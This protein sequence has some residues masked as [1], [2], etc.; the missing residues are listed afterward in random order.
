MQYCILARVPILTNTVK[1]GY[2]KIN[3]LENLRKQWWCCVSLF[4]LNTWK[5]IPSGHFLAIYQITK[6]ETVSDVP[7][8]KIRNKH[9]GKTLKKKSQNW[10]ILVNFKPTFFFFNFWFFYG[11]EVFHFYLPVGNY[12]PILVSN[13]YFPNQSP[14]LRL[15]CWRTKFPR[16]L[17]KNTLWNLKHSKP[18]KHTWLLTLYLIVTW[19][20]NT[21][22]I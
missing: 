1:P 22:I 17:V 14:M 12:W 18:V 13:P 19:K 10:E 15:H 11:C 6:I 21:K 4:R 5:E 7:F 16:W 20:K 8:G 3:I 9:A 2:K